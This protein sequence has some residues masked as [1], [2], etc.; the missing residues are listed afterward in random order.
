MKLPLSECRYACSS[1][2]PTRD[3]FT[4]LRILDFAALEY[5]EIFGKTISNFPE[6]L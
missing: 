5:F 2:S 4:S 3:N 6:L 1:D